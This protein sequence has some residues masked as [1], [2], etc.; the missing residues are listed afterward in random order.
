MSF[1]SLL[2]P[3]VPF[4][5]SNHH[6][7]YPFIFSRKPASLDTPLLLALPLEVLQHIIEYLAQ[8]PEPSLAILRRTH[9]LFNSIISPADVCGISHSELRAQR[10]SRAES[11]CAY[12]FPPNHYPCY[13]CLN[14]KP[15]NAFTDYFTVHCAKWR[16]TPKRYC[17][18]CGKRYRK[19]TPGMTILV[20]GIPHCIC[21][22]CQR[23]HLIP[24]GRRQHTC[25][26]NAGP[27]TVLPISAAALRNLRYLKPVQRFMLVLGKH[28][29]FYF[30]FQLYRMMAAAIMRG[31]YVLRY[32]VWTIP[33]WWVL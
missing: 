10:L 33:R 19:Y 22:G 30:P 17:I 14:V 29:G 8:D 27:L 13:F 23:L 6:L 11:T 26:P 24:C 28:E 31:H 5:L 18:N 9:R 7:K 3:T 16:L 12:V 15:S 4:D 32:I 2:V 21:R 1:D 25:H 20:E